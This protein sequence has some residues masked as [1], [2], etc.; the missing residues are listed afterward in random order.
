MPCYNCAASV[1]RA[2]ASIAS[3]SHTP[4]EVIIVDDA[5]TDDTG[6]VLARLQDQ[7]EPGWIRVYRL[8]RNEGAA[9]AR[10]K[11]WNC[12]QSE[13]IAFLDADDTWHPRKLEIQFQVLQAHPDAEVVA[14]LHDF[15]DARSGEP[16]HGTPPVARVSAQRLL[17]K[18]RFVTPSVLL[19]R[20]LSRRFRAGQRYMEDHLLWMELAF[21]GRNILLVQLP[22]ATL[23]KPSYGADGL[24]ANLIGMERAELGNYRLLSREGHFGPATLVLLW[25]WSAAKFVR[26]LVLVSVRRFRG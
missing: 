25:A 3:Q 19:R 24:S 13:W 23:H 4:R 20:S 2:V 14:H 7:Y 9:G 1:G 16:L 11:G 12:A 22:L 10:N 8:E 15:A 6:S 21:E 5:S 26:R 18:N 17:W